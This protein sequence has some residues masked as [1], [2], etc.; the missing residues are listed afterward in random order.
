MQPPTAEQ[1]RAIARSFGMT[2]TAEDLAGIARL[3]AGMVPL[4]RC[5]ERHDSPRLP[6]RYPRSRHQA[7]TPAGNPY[8]AW[9][10]LSDIRGA[11]EG[12]LRGKRVGIKDNIA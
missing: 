12:P 3:S 7:P 9:A 8:N 1:L 11:A 5:L 10:C 6:I 4:Y 2:I